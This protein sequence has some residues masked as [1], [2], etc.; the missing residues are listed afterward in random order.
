MDSHIAAVWERLRPPPIDIA[1]LTP[2]IAL[3]VIPSARRLQQLKRLGVSSIVDLRTADERAADPD[4]DAVASSLGFDILPLP[5]PDGSAPTVA[6]LVAGSVWIQQAS[7]TERS[8]LIG[9]P[10]GAGRTATLAAAM[11]VVV[12][13]YS[14]TEALRLVRTVRSLA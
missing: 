8:V 14:L 6:Q 1:W 4:W 13:G 12:F 2:A 3:G 5:V 9:C 11:L 7:A 10:A